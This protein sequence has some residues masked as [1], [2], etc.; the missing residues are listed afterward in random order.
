MI[1][2][3]LSDLY[4]IFLAV[5]NDLSWHRIDSRY[6]FLGYFAY[7]ILPWLSNCHRSSGHL[8]ST[9]T[10]IFAHFDAI[11]YVGNLSDLSVN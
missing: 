1:S 8:S 9:L 6:S 7:S 4:W 5:D 2:M 3:L 10:F 11:N